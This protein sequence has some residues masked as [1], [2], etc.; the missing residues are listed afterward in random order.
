MLKLRNLDNRLFRPPPPPRW[1]GRGRGGEG[2]KYQRHTAVPYTHHL[3]VSTV[4]KHMGGLALTRTTSHHAHHAHHHTITPVCQYTRVSICRYPPAYTSAPL[5][6]S[7]RQYNSVYQA[8]CAPV[9]GCRPAALRPLTP[10]AFL[11]F[12]PRLTT[13]VSLPRSPHLWVVGVRGV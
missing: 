2:D 12:L 9:G 3:S 7:V 11:L 5:W 4:P 6:H 13:R 8:P 1:R 10:Y